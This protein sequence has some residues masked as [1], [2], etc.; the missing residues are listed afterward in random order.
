[1]RRA[2]VTHGLAAQYPYLGA[3]NNP[4]IDHSDLKQNSRL[5]RRG[6]PN[7]QV[8]NRLCYILRTNA[9]ADRVR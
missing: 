7:R 9:F 2:V 4:L 1:M 3:P 5:L 6:H 8:L